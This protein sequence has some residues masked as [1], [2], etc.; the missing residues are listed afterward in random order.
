MEKLFVMDSNR[1]VTLLRELDVD[2]R[3][4]WNHLPDLWVLVHEG[5]ILTVLQNERQLG[6]MLAPTFNILLLLVLTVQ[7]H[8]SW[9]FLVCLHRAGHT[10][11]FVSLTLLSLVIQVLHNV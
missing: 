10:T 1:Y 3:G 6:D 11:F 5:D 7:F 9:K 8:P 2:N 4:W